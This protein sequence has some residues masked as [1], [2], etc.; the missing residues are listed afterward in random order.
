M[1]RET[2]N[3][4]LLLVGVSAG[5]VAVTGAYTRYVKAAV[6]PWLLM[7]AVLLITLAL[8]AILRDMRRGQDDHDPGGHRHRSGIVWL[9]VLPVVALIFVVPPALSPRAIGTSV[10]AVS[11]NVLRRPFPPLPP[12]RAPAMSLRDVLT[13]VAEDSA[14]TLDGRLITVTGFTLKDDGRTDLARVVITCCAADA[15]LARIRLGGPA[16]AAATNRPDNT[17]LTIEGKVVP[18]QRNS[19]TS[20]PTLEASRVTPI[21]PPSNPYA[22]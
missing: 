13:R 20:V 14:G 16:A 8:T 7:A 6:L 17:W 18:A 3:A 11:T 12:E 15:R 10:V 2:E 19:G 22:Y 1:N 5:V 9:L 21:D 4:L